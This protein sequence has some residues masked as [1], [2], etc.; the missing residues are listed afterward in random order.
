MKGQKEYYLPHLV[1]GKEI[2]CFTLTGLHAD[3]DIMSIPDSSVICKG[4]YQ[5]HE[6]IGIRL[7]W[8]KVTSCSHPSQY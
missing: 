3:S 8:D 7:N 5:N 6:T 4:N 1:K 2:G